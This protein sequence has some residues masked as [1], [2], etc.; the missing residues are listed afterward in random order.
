MVITWGSLPFG[1]RAMTPLQMDSSSN[2]SCI[3]VEI[4]IFIVGLALTTGHQSYN[5]YDSI[6]NSE[7]H[8]VGTYGTDRL[9]R[10]R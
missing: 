9:A 7:K 8:R 5:F 10:W 1:R 3:K 2:K 4:S 6:T